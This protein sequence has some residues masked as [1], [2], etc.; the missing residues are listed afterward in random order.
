[1]T[2]MDETYDRC[3]VTVESS[4]TGSIL[5]LSGEFDIDVADQLRDVLE[6]ALA[7]SPMVVLDV[8]EV[9]FIDSSALN[10]LLAARVKATPY[11]VTR[12]NR[13]VDR[14]FEITGLSFLYD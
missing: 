13:V 4:S 14:L 6:T 2:A 8:E 7:T 11:R 10:V 3:F 9:T 5:H 12:G 1:M